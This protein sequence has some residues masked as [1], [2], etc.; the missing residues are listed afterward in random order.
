MV[1]Q[2]I[3]QQL[4][5][6]DAVYDYGFDYDFWLRASAITQLANLPA[7]L[8]SL[9]IHSDSSSQLYR[10]RQDYH[11]IMAQKRA[12]TAFLGKPV[13]LET[14]CAL[15]HIE[16]TAT[17]SGAYKSVSVLGELYQIYIQSMPLSANE[18]HQIQGHFYKHHCYLML[19]ALH[20]PRMMAAL[21]G[22]NFERLRHI[23]NFM[24]F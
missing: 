10:A 14:V 12:I 3:Y 18:R 15:S 23:A 11:A 22:G 2:S 19:K 17:P 6:Y 5:G 8:L 13:A 9:R 7:V 4:Q 21:L 24:R 1:R 20:L 16:K